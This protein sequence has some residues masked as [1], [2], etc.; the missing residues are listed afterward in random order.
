MTTAAIE[1]DLIANCPLYA[2]MLIDGVASGAPYHII[3]PAGT[4][5]IFHNQGFWVRVTGDT[6]W[7]VT[8]Y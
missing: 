6:T 3:T 5:N 7:T 4:E 2:E 1:A 8:N